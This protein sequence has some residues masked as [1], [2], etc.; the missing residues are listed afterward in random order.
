MIH[1]V[2]HTQDHFIIEL[3]PTIS[4]IHTYRIEMHHSVLFFCILIAFG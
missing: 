2:I 4:S 1:E 3:V